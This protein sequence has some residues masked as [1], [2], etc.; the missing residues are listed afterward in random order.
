[1]QRMSMPSAE[2]ET[3]SSNIHVFDDRLCACIY[4]KKSRSSNDN[5]NEDEDED[6][7][8]NCKE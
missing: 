4:F 3:K 8:N 1:M 5:D 7:R 2:S 6:G